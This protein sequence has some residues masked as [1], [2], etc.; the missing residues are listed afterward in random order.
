MRVVVVGAGVAGTASA[1]VLANAGHE[2]V[3]VDRDGPPPPG[4]LTTAADDWDRPGVP[5][6][7]QPHNFLGLGRHLLE[8]VFPD[9]RQALLV[10]GATE[11]DQRMF[12]PAD[13]PPAEGDALLQVLQ[14]RRPV[15][16][17]ALRV[18]A[19]AAGVT[20][21]A[22]TVTG[23]AVSGDRVTSV[24]LDGQPAR[25][26][27]LVVDAAG[28]GS[29]SAGWLSAVGLGSPTEEHTDCGLVY[30]SRH[31]ALRD[32]VPMPAPASVLAGPRG[33]IGFLSY[34]VFVGDNRTFC[35]TLIPAATDRAFRDLR[36]PD[37]FLRVL[38]LMPGCAGWVDPDVAAPI[39]SVLPMGAL[40]DVVR[41][42]PTAANPGVVS[43]GDAVVH[44]NP[45]HA[46]GASQG[47]Q[48]ATVLLDVLAEVADPTRVA[49]AFAE[50]TGDLARRRYEAVA[51]EDRDRLRMYAGEPLDVLDPGSSLPLFLRLGLPRVVREDVDLLRALL[52]RV[53]MLDPPDLLA[54]DADLLARGAAL[55]RDLAPLPVPSRDEVLAALAG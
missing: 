12:F 43:V 41:S 50:R 45:T 40:R 27:D 37:A 25:P 14:C 2:V 10:A 8:T 9:V 19:D 49:A 29:H 42:Q 16:D 11:L 38:R 52:R 54:G 31:F 1:T 36:D 55:C 23:V 15:F 18:A 26:A 44:T 13:A 34:V 3:L 28:R 17:A 6:L 33:E 30:Y 35:A 32:G 22:G 39:S 53:N 46:Y 24:V 4:P 48:H 20:T 5:Q 51:A 21:A 7:R 47:L